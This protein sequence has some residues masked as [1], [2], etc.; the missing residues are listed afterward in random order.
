L[1]PFPCGGGWRW[2][3]GRRLPAIPPL[4]MKTSL[5]QDRRSF[6]NLAGSAAALAPGGLALA[7]GAAGPVVAREGDRPVLLLGIACS[8]RAGKTTA[9]AVRTALESAAKVNP[10][11][12]TELI[13][14]GGKRIAG[15]SPEPVSDDFDA[16]LARLKDPALGGLIIGSPSFFR[17]LSSL[18]KAFI[19]R[20][21]PLREAPAALA[22]KP[23]GALA[24]AGN[25]HG[26]QELVVQQIL[27]AM[28]S[29]GMIP[30]GGNA[31]ALLG[32]TV[33]NKAGD[34]VAN[35]PDGLATAR[36]LGTRVATMALKLIP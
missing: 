12:R 19:E 10:R 36:L 32:G 15:W 27:T 20:C 13:D 4:P 3:T 24:I 1:S 28:L 31:P 26:G 16:V 35:D 23:V 11:I 14:L 2:L 6:L 8:P 17:S 22:D 33:W 30:V 29:Y 9:A 21:M 7:A 34:D 5:I 18:C 25:R